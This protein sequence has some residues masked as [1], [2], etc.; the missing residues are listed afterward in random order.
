M[1]FSLKCSIIVY[2]L[3]GVAELAD[4]SDSKSGGSDIVSVRPRSPVL[5]NGIL[6]MKDAVFLFA[7][8]AGISK[9]FVFGSV[10]F[11]IFKSYIA[12]YKSGLL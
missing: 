9:R 12:I 10:H 8:P 11:F 1:I 5:K 2:A 3:A 4:A 7:A 6:L